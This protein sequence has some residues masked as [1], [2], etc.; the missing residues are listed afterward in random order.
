MSA[1]NKSKYKVLQ[2]YL[3][4]L[5]YYNNIRDKFGLIEARCSMGF[6]KETFR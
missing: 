3:S 5:L 2:N 6:F 4:H 1:V